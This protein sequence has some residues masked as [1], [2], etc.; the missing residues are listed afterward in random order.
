MRVLVGGLR[1]L[2]RLVLLEKIVSMTCHRVWS[3]FQRVVEIH[4][5][6]DAWLT[7][8]HSVMDYQKDL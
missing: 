5:C 3:R 4:I 6:E 7:A 8:I 1:D 2:Q